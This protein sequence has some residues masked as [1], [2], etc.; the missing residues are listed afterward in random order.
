MAG[1]IATIIAS[2]GGIGLIGF[3]VYMAL[4]GVGD[5]E[6]EEAARE[7]YSEHGHWPDEAPGAS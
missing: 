7:Y 5:R 1:T 6:D 2:I 4:D 3:L